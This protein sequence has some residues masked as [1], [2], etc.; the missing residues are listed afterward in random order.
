MQSRGLSKIFI[1]KD[2]PIPP[3][4]CLSLVLGRRKGGGGEA[5]AQLAHDSAEAAGG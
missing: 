3:I 2:E 4:H 5:R 1:T